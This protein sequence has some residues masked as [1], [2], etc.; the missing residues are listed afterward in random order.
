MNQKALS[1]QISQTEQFANM[2]D[3]TVSISIVIRGTRLKIQSSLRVKN[4]NFEFESISVSKIKHVCHI[5]ET[6]KFSK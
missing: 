6:F 5:R 2:S 3:D 4:S 1:M